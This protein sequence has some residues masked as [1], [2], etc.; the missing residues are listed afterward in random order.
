M[1]EAEERIRLTAGYPNRIPRRLLF[2]EHYHGLFCVDKKYIIPTLLKPNR[3]SAPQIRFGSIFHT[4]ST[5]RSINFAS[6]LAL[7]FMK[8][9]IFPYR[10]HISL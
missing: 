4:M 3:S 9:S 8:Y 6:Q 7:E 1:E 2:T 10:K 5:L